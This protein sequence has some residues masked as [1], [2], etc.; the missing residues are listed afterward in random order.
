MRSK[1]L[2]VGLKENELMLKIPK[3]LDKSKVLF[4]FKQSYPVA[5]EQLF[6]HR[7]KTK[8]RDV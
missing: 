3:D 4:D 6:F 2:S 7:I 8:P 1:I 5:K